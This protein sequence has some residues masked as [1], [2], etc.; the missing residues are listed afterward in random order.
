M[1]DENEVIDI[2]LAKIVRR[3]IVD[4]RQIILLCCSNN[5]PSAELQNLVF[6]GFFFI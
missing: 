4:A 1:R 6:V 2:F 3:A 5:S